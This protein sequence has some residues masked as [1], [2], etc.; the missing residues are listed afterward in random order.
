M[1][2]NQSGLP[3]WLISHSAGLLKNESQAHIVIFVYLLAAFVVT[4]VL[5]TDTTVAEI[6]A[7]TGYEII[8]DG[9]SPPYLKPL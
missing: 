5:F 4:Y 1:G 6:K 7:P 9:K 8:D 3:S 2:N